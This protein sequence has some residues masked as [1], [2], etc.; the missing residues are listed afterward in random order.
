MS[1]QPLPDP[2]AKAVLARTEVLE[3]GPHG[4]VE[5]D[6]GCPP[7]GRVQHVRAAAPPPKKKNEKKLESEKS[8]TERE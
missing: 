8:V 2:E 3:L 6:G 4:G 7:C 5:A 1:W